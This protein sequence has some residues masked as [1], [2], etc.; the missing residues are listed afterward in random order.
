[1]HA[2]DRVVAWVFVFIQLLLLAAVFLLP[3]KS[4]W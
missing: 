2:R 1:M 3:A 4:A